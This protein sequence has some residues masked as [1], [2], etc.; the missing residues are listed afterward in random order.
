MV[1]AYS[2]PLDSLV[3]QYERQL[4]Y[5]VRTPWTGPAFSDKDAWIARDR[6]QRAC[7]NAKTAYAQARH[8]GEAIPNAQRDYTAALDLERRADAL[9]LGRDAYVVRKPFT[10]ISRALSAIARWWQHCA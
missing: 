6:A 5:A 4:A 1:D 7:D 9:Y 2:T 8:T 3:E 10:Y